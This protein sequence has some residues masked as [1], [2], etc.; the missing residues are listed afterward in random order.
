MSY[1]PS[2]D[3]P[4]LGGD[5]EHVGTLP[6]R[7]IIS[8]RIGRTLLRLRDLD[9]DD[10]QIQRLVEEHGSMVGQCRRVAATIPSQEIAGVYGMV[11]V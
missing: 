10:K 8:P 5:V 1:S 9:R 3:K 2:K 11:G 4:I 7:R 6:D